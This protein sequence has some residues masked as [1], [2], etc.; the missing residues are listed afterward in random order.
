MSIKEK[1]KVK[2]ISKHLCKEWLLHKHYAKR[3]P[4]ISYAFGLF[5]KDLIGICTLGSPPSRA[6]CVGVCGK[7]NSNKVLELNR[8]CVND[9]LERNVLSYF[10]S[11]C[12]K[13]LKNELIIVS[14]A[15]T[16][17]SH[18]GYIYQATN[19]IYTGLSAKRTERY[20]INNPNR[21][22]KSVTEQKGVNYQDLAIRARPQK[23]RYIYFTGN[24]KQIKKL[25]KELNY[26]IK[27]YPK[28]QNKRYNSSYKP[29]IQRELF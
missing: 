6:L 9:N 5:D 17:M 21:H 26:K 11:S 20:D 12:L 16:S 1:Y 18:N 7:H 13:L 3:I 8:L 29:T 15:D 24:K 10:V 22:S 23:H 28:G 2:S 4:S 14:Y 19:W 25:K 27:P